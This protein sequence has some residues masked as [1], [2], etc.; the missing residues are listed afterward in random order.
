MH[1]VASATAPYS[2][3]IECD[4]QHMLDQTCTFYPAIQLAFIMM[5]TLID[6]VF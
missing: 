6:T 5:D 3:N 4:L 2:H 1:I